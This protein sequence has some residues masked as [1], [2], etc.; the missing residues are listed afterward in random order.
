MAKWW[1]Q[2]PSKRFGTK[3][4]TPAIVQCDVEIDS[5]NILNLCDLKGFKTYVNFLDKFMDLNMS[6]VEDNIDIGPIDYQTLR[7]LFFDNI[8]S[9]SNISAIYAPFYAEKQPY[10]PTTHNELFFKEMNIMYIEQQFCLKEGMQN[11]IVSKKIL[12]V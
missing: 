6:L 3:V 4:H 10:F 5:Q 12:E 1:T 11:L 9:V 7:C 8:F 2:N